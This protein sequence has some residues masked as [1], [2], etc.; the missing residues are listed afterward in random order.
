MAQ[1]LRTAVVT[2]TARPHG[3]GRATARAFVKAGYQVLGVDKLKLQDADKGVRFSMCTCAVC[4][5]RADAAAT[6][7]LA[8]P[9]QVAAV[10]PQLDARQR[11][12]AGRCTLCML[13]YGLCM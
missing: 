8:C 5:P 4:L 1:G 9:G 2:G 3:I 13:R 11:R 12:G 6:D 10:G 7:G